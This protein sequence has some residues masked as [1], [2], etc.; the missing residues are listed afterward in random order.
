MADIKA[1]IEVN[2]KMNTSS[3]DEGVRDV[4]TQFNNLSSQIDAGLNGD[5][6]VSEQLLN[7]LRTSFAAL[8]DSTLNLEGII[9]EAQF[10]KALELVFN[11]KEKL[12]ELKVTERD[13]SVGEFGG[14]LNQLKSAF[15]LTEEETKA[16]QRQEAIRQ[17]LVDKINEMYAAQAGQSNVIL[18]E[19]EL[20]KELVNAAQA[21]NDEW[22]DTGDY[23]QSVEEQLETQRNQLEAEKAVLED[24]HYP[25]EEL[26][27]D[28]P[29]VEHFSKLVEVL[30]SKLGISNS[31]AAGL[32]KS[33][34]ATAGEAAAAGVAI[35]VIVG[36]L[37][38]YV[39][40]LHEAEDALKKLGEGLLNAGVNGVQYFI[41]AMGTLVD[42][43]DEALGKMEE[44]AEKG[45]E[46]QT[47]YYNTFTVLGS[48][49]GEEVL[50]FAD[51]LEHL[52][53]LDGDELVEDMQSLVAAA[54]SLGVNTDDMVK[55]T[56]NMTIMS[57]NLSI[58]AG[59]FQK[60]SND[61]GNAISKG[62]VGRNSVLYVLMTKQEKEALKD[63]NSEVERYNY[64]MSLSGRIK[65]RYIAF[66]GTEAGKIMLMNNQ[67]SI[68][69]NNISKL[70]L[71]LYAKIAPLL[72]ELIKLAN[73][74]LTWIMKVFNIDI[75]SSADTGTGSIAEGITNTMK[76]A[77][78]SSKNAAKDIKKS[79]KDS[80]KALKELERQVA[81]FDDVIQI[82]DNKANDDL[83]D[84]DD[85]DTDL[86]GIG[87]L[88]DGLQ[89]LIGDFN[90][91]DEA[92]DTTNHEFDEFWE[93]ID[94]GDY[95]GAGQWLADWLTKKMR[96]IPW[97]EIQDKASKFGK[98]FAELLNGLISQKE[99]WAEFGRMI[100]EALDTA[101]TFLLEFAKEFDFEGLGDSLAV[102][103][104]SF[105]DNF[106]KEKAG[107]ALYEWFIGVF[108]LLNGFFK[109]N[110]LTQLA[111][112]LVDIIDSFFKSL[113]ED[114]DA[115][116]EM[117]ETVV[118]FID[119]VVRSAVILLSGVLE[120]TD[121][122]IDIIN[123]I[124]DSI[125]DWLENGGG[126]KM[127]RDI[128]KA[129]VAI[130]TKIKESGII[131]KVKEIIIKV[132]D[133]I[134]LGD[135]L[136]VATDIALEV[137]RAKTEIKLKYYWEK[138]KAF[139]KSLDI[140]GALERFGQLLLSLL[141]AL[142]ANIFSSIVDGWKLDSAMDLVTNGALLALTGGLQA[143]IVNITAF[144]VANKEKIEEFINNVKAGIETVKTFI[145]QGWNNIK[146]IANSI[147]TAITKFF[148]PEK[149]KKIGVDA[150]NGLFNGIKDIIQKIK[151][152][153]NEHLIDKLN[154]FS[155][156][157]PSNRV[158]QAAGIAGGT[159]GFHIPRLMAAGGIVN[160]ATNAIIG[161][162]GR[163]AVLPLDKNTGWMDI[164]A[165]KMADINGGGNNTPVVID[166]SKATK[167]VYTR[168]EY[169]AM[170]DIFAEAMKARGVAVS[171]EY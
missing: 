106:D 47:A 153:I 56:E 115:K 57:N 8:S 136:A 170:A 146:A 169:L 19:T 30:A 138:I 154:S 162:A 128:G 114:E 161:E 87:D 75:K 14:M 93:K 124:I 39:D 20:Q 165:K 84:L 91:L 122:I 32:A 107:Q 133:D 65:E 97:D 53:G 40:R 121:E 104:K 112:G 33:L 158:T 129:I 160:G 6:K 130:L 171:M 117:A 142:G 143:I 127:L 110:P 59:S 80:K 12:E 113:A 118:N 90:L 155:I 1:N 42:S 41:D 43:L 96:E 164:L 46:I 94:A 68:L 2:A 70:A 108:K 58:L 101:V 38:I 109:H 37:K 64:L 135:I 25:G 44:F 78:E 148:S 49:A 27:E 145:E 67:Y 36:V 168:S 157:I 119:D 116:S 73:R 16:L 11:L 77:G 22:I 10:D 61:I 156:T 55:A 13:L 60:A 48:E 159:I 52:Y 141:A 4:I 34:G 163:E 66:L 28:S 140:S 150:F 92:I 17:V 26:E 105:W 103:W 98:G 152:F 151:N 131:D 89:D 147:W 31:E 100:A 82:K 95:F 35:G 3:V 18:T 21:Y 79:T 7:D 125:A 83:I 149:W 74:A 9:P 5:L 167:P 76:K 88:D 120:H 23:V 86:D 54:G 166:I 132:M 63:L 139:F 71:G 85:L 99:L 126:D 69:M 123:N 137:W 24:M 72:T 111:G 29:K 45:A 81:S 50:D 15:E 144:I 134:G 62:F 51:K 102:A